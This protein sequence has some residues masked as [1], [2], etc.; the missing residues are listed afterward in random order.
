M[1]KK[2]SC[3]K[4]GKEKDERAST[5]TSCHKD[6]K[7]NRKTCE[8]CGN[9]F[10]GRG[11]QFCSIQCRNNSYERRQEIT[12]LSCGGKFFIPLSA[13][14]NNRGK[15][16]SRK[17]FGIG[18]GRAMTGKRW[19]LPESSKGKNH[20]LY[21]NRTDHFCLFCGELYHTKPAE[22]KTTKF[23]S[24]KCHGAWFIRNIQKPT[25][26]EVKIEN[27]LKS[28]GVNYTS[29]SRVYKYLC[30]FQIKNL[31]IETDGDYWHGRERQI[32]KDAKR[33]KYLKDNGYF[34]LRLKEADINN[35]IDWCEKQIINSLKLVVPDP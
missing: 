22:D 6:G 15:Y 14:K 5:C 21:K 24:Y 12:C 4:C 16:C 7:I 19:S 26:I 9:I 13:T 8:Y 35:R 10:V 32:E 25:S 29:Q 30:D 18:H 33:D 2:N 31:I 11:K 23:C 28:L 3:P 17:C 34:V 20:A 1:H 27:V